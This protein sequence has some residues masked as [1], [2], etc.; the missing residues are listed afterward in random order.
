EQDKVHG[1]INC[2]SGKPVKLKQLVEDYLASKSRSIHLNLG[3][4][5][6]PDYEAMSF[7][8]DDA[9][10]RRALDEARKS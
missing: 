1:I 2:C 4:Y 10:L 5:P 6:Y 3:Y 7:W 8:G 9:K